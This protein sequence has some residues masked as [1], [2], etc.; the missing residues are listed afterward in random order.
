[1]KPKSVKSYLKMC[2]AICDTDRD[3]LKGIGK[4][5]EA[6]YLILGDI[7]AGVQNELG[8]NYELLKKYKLE[9]ESRG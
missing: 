2:I 4:L 3:S 9:N 6:E 5:T 8:D 7:R 1:M